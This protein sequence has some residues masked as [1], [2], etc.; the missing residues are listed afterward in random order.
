MANKKLDVVIIGAGAAGLAAARELHDKG[1]DVVVLEARDRIGGRVWTHHD[2]EAP[3]PIE[4]G[5]EFIHGSAE[6]TGKVIEEAELKSFDVGGRRCLVGARRDQ[7]LDDFWEQLYR[8]MHLM[9]P[10]SRVAARLGLRRGSD[11]SVQ[12]FL[13]TKPGGKGLVRERKLA[14][15]FVEG[16]HAADTRLISAKALVD[17]GTPGE[18]MDETRL[19]RVVGGY[20]GVI[21][22]IAA[23]IAMRIRP[24]SVVTRV[25]WSPKRVLVE[26]VR[27][28]SRFTVNA[29]AAIVAV[30][31]GVLQ[32][33]AFSVG[34]IEFDPLLGPAKQEALGCL[35]SGTVVRVVLQLREALWADDVSFM[36]S[37]DPDFD[38]WWTSYPMRAPVI[39]GW[40]GGPGATRLLQ[41]PLE[42]IAARSIASLARHLHTT[43]KRVQ[44]LV[45]GV[46]M[47]DWQNDPFARGAYSY[48]L[49]G[50]GEATDALARPL[51]GT[52]F[53]AGEATGS[54]GSTGT[55]DGAIGTG[56]RAAKQVLAGW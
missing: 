30:P 33:P 39:V 5:A 41:M 22:A 44:G 16:F 21:E 11:F 26:G 14:K 53:F 43:T 7:P 28:R 37:S 17:S 23:P 31:L 32:A 56:R 10:P 1:L 4:M 8:A 29:R 47:H 13:D 20:T 45:Q 38:V 25:Q 9:D 2:P 12:D 19:G 18:D 51:K 3:V 48:Q 55:V 50:G 15:Q 36:H 35:T 42:E 54:G 6:E 46:W 52:L 24:G 49:V 40:R 27:G 34:A